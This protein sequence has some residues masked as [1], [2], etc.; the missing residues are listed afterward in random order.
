MFFN[1]ISEKNSFKTHL[2]IYLPTKAHFNEWLM[3]VCVWEREREI[4]SIYVSV[5]RKIE[6]EF[7]GGVV[8]V[9]IVRNI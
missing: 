5:D 1:L 2:S 3:C 4:V 6:Q 7:V 9:Y 8:C